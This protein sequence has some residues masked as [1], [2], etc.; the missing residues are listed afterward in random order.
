MPL[1]DF[2]S[3]T[4]TRQRQLPVVTPQ[5]L[6]FLSTEND[7]G[8]EK[9][10]P[11][12]HLRSQANSPRARPNFRISKHGR[13]YTCFHKLQAH[14]H[15]VS[16][17]KKLVQHHQIV[18]DLCFLTRFNLGDFLSELSHLFQNL[19]FCR[20]LKMRKRYSYSFYETKHE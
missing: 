10:Q 1:A 18:L 16:Y 19:L 15:E 9:R 17:L 7:F 6:S 13:I 4:A 11:E 14:D 20:Y 2:Y 5:Q 3:P 12:I 8:G